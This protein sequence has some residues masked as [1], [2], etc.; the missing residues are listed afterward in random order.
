MEFL[1]TWEIS[2]I[3]AEADWPQRVVVC[4]SAE[5]VLP[6]RVGH[7]QVITGDRWQLRTEHD[8]GAGWRPN[9]RT[10]SDPPQRR[11]NR[12]VRTVR[13]KDR[14]WAGD[15][16][17]DDL[18]LKL[19]GRRRAV[20][21]PAVDLS[22]APDGGWLLTVQVRSDG[23]ESLGFSTGLRICAAGRADLAAAGA[24]V[25]DDWPVG[26]AQERIGDLS[27][28]PPLPPGELAAVQFLLEATRAPSRLPGFDLVNAE[29]QVVL[30]Q[31]DSPVQEA[32]EA[33]RQLPRAAVQGRVAGASFPSR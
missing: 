28:L 16:I 14:D 15:H 19:E 11:G 5:V 26:S 27:I 21:L 6:G 33:P 23:A 10:E 12:I 24:V 1:G 32:H 29:N 4:G 22:P 20:T 30:Q 3:G 31:V 8:S 2:V 9:A 13:S 25:V 7:R 17:P 18:I